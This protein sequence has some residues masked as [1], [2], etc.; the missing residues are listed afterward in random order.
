MSEG[1][2][3]KL[4]V[5]RGSNP[6][7]F[8]QGAC[9]PEVHRTFKRAQRSEDGFGPNPCGARRDSTI[10][11]SLVLEYAKH[12]LASSFLELALSRL[13]VTAGSLSTRPNLLA[14]EWGID[15]I[16]FCRRAFRLVR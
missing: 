10:S 3:D 5:D 12:V 16:W 11:V 14:D 8:S 6:S 15:P 9:A 4:S 13:A 2:V 7:L 1:R